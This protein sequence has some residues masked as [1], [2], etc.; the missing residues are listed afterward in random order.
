MVDPTGCRSGSFCGH[1]HK[2]HALGVRF[3]RVRNS[4]QSQKAHRAG[5]HIAIGE[6][7]ATTRAKAIACRGNQAMDVAGSERV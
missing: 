5:T 1:V 7:D 3:I 6:R 4:Q 2:R